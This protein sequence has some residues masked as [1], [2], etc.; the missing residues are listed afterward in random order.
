MILSIG[1]RSCS[2]IGVFCFVYHIITVCHVLNVSCHST[3][4][5][6]VKLYLCVSFNFYHY[7]WFLLLLMVIIW[8]FLLL[9]MFVIYF[10][11]FL[12]LIIWDFL[13]LLM[14]IIWDFLLV[15]ML[16][17]WD[18]LLLLMFFIWD[19]YS[20]SCS[21]Y[22]IVYLIFVWCDFLIKRAH[23]KIILC[24]IC[25]LWKRERKKY[26]RTVHTLTMKSSSDRSF[27]AF[28]S[29][30]FISF[31]GVELTCCHK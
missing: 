25:D 9:L 11:L 8:D 29:L 28:I 10:L 6:V 1:Y 7:K 24:L 3:K 15:L 22:E 26:G 2:D 18:F 4:E 12:M 13:L 16:I 23:W 17:I 21:L 30:S 27:P 31:S 14:L 20:L 19:F 5:L